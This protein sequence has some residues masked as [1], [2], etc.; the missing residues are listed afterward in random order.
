MTHP[1]LFQAFLVN[2]VQ[3]VLRSI[4]LK[5]SSH[6]FVFQVDRASQS[7]DR[8]SSPSSGRSRKNAAKDLYLENTVYHFLGNCGWFRGKVDGN[9]PQLVFQVVQIGSFESKLCQTHLM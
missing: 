5:L 8:W 2:F 7:R 1:D 4:C 9:L 3:P 6:R